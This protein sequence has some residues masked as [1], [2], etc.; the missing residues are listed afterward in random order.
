MDVEKVIPVC[1]EA[2][3]EV[4]GKRKEAR[5][6]GEKASG[7]ERGQDGRQ[8]SPLPLFSGQNSVAKSVLCVSLAQ[9]SC[10]FVM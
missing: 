6:A 10:W 9:H 4:G 3:E 5:L 1:G 8:R 2:Q 7:G